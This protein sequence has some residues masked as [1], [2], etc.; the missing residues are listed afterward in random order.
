[1]N[2]GI[3]AISCS[4]LIWNCYA[5]AS[6]WLTGLKTGVQKREGKAKRNQWAR[7]KT[8]GKITPAEKKVRVSLQWSDFSFFLWLASMR[9]RGKQPK[10]LPR[11]VS[12]REVINVLVQWSRCSVRARTCWLKTPDIWGVASVSPLNRR[13]FW[14]AEWTVWTLLKCAAI[15][16][17]FKTTWVYQPSIG[18]SLGYMSQSCT[19]S[20]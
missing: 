17:L 8:M 12:W 13:R 18:N 1:M 4:S 3:A 16:I 6:S 9:R 11:F 20:A 15:F 7:K 2:G 19:S 10:A 5:E 14:C